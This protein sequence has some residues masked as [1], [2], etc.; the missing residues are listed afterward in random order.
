M[1]GPMRSSVLADLVETDPSTV[2]RQVAT[3]VRQGLLERRADQDDGRAVLLHPTAEAM[4][5]HDQHLR[6]RE[7]HYREMLAGWSAQD[8][9]LFAELLARFTDS[10]DVYRPTFLAAL[11]TEFPREAQQ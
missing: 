7:A 9:R 8:Q 5:R 1:H 3:L 4:L 10:F 11:I 2:S 6:L